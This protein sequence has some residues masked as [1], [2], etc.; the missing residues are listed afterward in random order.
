MGKIILRSI[1]ACIMIALAICYIIN[2]VN[3]IHASLIY[4]AGARIFFF[5]LG[6][7]FFT[8]VWLFTWERT[9]FLRTSIHER[10][11]ALIFAIFGHS[12]REMYIS[13]DYNGHGHVTTHG[14]ASGIA[15]TLG[16]LAPYCLPYL[17]GL[18][19]I[20]LPLVKPELYRVY[21]FMLGATFATIS[22]IFVNLVIYPV[23]AVKPCPSGRGYKAQVHSV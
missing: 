14:P 4:G 10:A 12:V 2:L 19:L 16:T 5:A 6:M 11:H 23:R 3:M 21:F 17:V 22:I 9:A 15:I 20:F 13:A 8:G 1:L 18:F 7:V